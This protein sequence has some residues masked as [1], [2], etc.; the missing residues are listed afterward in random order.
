MALAVA[1][2][3]HAQDETA[4]TDPTTPEAAEAPEP[5]PPSRLAPRP[6]PPLMVAVLTT[7]RVPEAVVSAVESAVVASVT[8]MAGGRAVHP[9]AAAEL[10]SALAACRDDA[11]IGALL[12]QAGAQG[13]VIVRMT[14]RGRAARTALELRDPVSGTARQAPVQGDVPLDAATAGSAARALAEQLRDAMPSP[15]PRPASLTITVNV[16]GAQVSVDGEA[17]GLSPVA[18]IDVVEGSHE[19]TVLMPG[20]RS[21]RRQVRVSP[22]E[23]AR[24]DVNLA[25]AGADAAAMLSGDAPAA[26]GDVTGEWWFWTAI[27][28]GAAV[29]VGIAIALGVAAGGGGAGP[30]EPTGVMLPPILGGM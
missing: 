22:A 18:P 9:L 15:P 17:L 12:A 8:A 25:P 29:L 26:G 4:E 19:V 21:V 24:V 13:G 11:C 3:A 6:P 1:S 2:P 20:Y 14:A 30:Q 7:G 28:G 27:G 5:P 10:R 23:Q 16:D